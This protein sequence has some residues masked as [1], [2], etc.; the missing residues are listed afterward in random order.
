MNDSSVDEAGNPGVKGQTEKGASAKADQGRGVLCAVIFNN[1]AQK[2]GAKAPFPRPR[3][4]GA[5]A[6]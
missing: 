6:W 1:T 5:F 4:F 3:S 2:D